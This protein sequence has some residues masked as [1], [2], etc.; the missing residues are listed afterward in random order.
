M[1]SYGRYSFLIYFNRVCFSLTFQTLHV[2]VIERKKDDKF[3]TEYYDENINDRI[4]LPI[5]K[6][7]YRYF[8]V[9]LS[10]TIKSSFIIAY[11]QLQ[12]GTISSIMQQGGVEELRVLLKRH[13]DKVIYSRQKSLRILHLLIKV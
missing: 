12:Y 13:Y 6:M 2:P 1:Y 5:L 7:S 9:N 10:K 4:M 11:F 8:V 3:I